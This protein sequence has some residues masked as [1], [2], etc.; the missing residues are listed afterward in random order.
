MLESNCAATVRLPQVAYALEAVKRAAYE[1]MARYDISISLS[2]DEIICSI[3]Q[4]RPDVSLENAE[5]DFRREV[6]DQDLRISIE[7]RTDAYRDAILGLAFS[8]SGLQDG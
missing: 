3:E 2:A 1:L 8:K 4:A 5:R 7:Q 6:I